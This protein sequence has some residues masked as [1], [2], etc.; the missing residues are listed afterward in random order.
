MILED[1]FRRPSAIARYRTT[2]RSTDGRVLRVAS[3]AGLFPR[4]DAPADLA[5]LAFQS[6]SSSMGHPGLP[7]HP[8]FA[9]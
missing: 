3:R 2:T 4:C 6:V 8:R 7:A 9:Y 1:F 5:G